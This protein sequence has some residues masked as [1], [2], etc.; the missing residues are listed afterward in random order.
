MIAQDPWPLSQT[1]VLY[2]FDS[3]LKPDCRSEWREYLS[4]PTTKHM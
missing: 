2:G 3:L 4:L 1:P